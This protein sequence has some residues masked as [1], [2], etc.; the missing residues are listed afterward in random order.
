M[1]QQEL[2][3][4]VTDIYRSTH[5]LWEAS[6]QRLGADDHGFKILYAP[7]LFEPPLLLIGFQPAGS[8]QN[9]LDTEHR[10]PSKKNEYLSEILYAGERASQ[11]VWPVVPPRRGGN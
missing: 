8:R 1:G 11:A 10:E 5:E 4:I 9:M 7:A 3:R 6:R 2:D